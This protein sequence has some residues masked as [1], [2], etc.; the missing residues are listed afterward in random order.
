M[1]KQYPRSCF[2]PSRTPLM[3]A[4]LGSSPE[5]I[6]A[7]L[8]AGADVNTE[9]EKGE[10]ALLCT[11]RH[12]DT[13]CRMMYD[14][15][16]HGADVNYRSHQGMTP[17]I[18]AARSR[19]VKVVDFLLCKG[20]N[21]TEIYHNVDGDIT[22]QDCSVFDF[23]AAQDWP[24]EDISDVAV[25]GLLRKYIFSHANDTKER[26]ARI[27]EHANIDGRTVL[28]R[29]AAEGMVL[30]VEALLANGVP[31]NPVEY[32]SR[33]DSEGKNQFRLSWFETPL[34]VAWSMKDKIIKNMRGRSRF[35]LRENKEFLAKAEKII[36]M[37][38]DAGGAR[39]A[40]EIT[41]KPFVLDKEKYGERGLIQALRAC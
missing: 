33:R 19:L 28:H 40:N 36:T 41:K 14:L 9:N 17:I 16:K 39:K 18:I 21:A 15:I 12:K 11:S 7:L 26:R 31:V 5:V 38:T 30:C 3:M 34:D 1:G 10:T 27:L 29:F 2:F 35:T 6:P 20:A 22:N 23:L 4:A 25:L 8:A 32:C 24:F 37:L 13:T